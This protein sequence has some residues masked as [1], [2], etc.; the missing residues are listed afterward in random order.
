MRIVRGKL[1]SVFGMEVSG[2]GVV[3]QYTNIFQYVNFNVL[4]H[5]TV[6][7]DSSERPSR[8]MNGILVPSGSLRSPYRSADLTEKDLDVFCVN[9]FHT[10]HKENV[11]SCFPYFFKHKAGHFINIKKHI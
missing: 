7:P 3:V 2:W 1:F 8:R 11:V 10:G 6:T 9:F 5:A 4:V